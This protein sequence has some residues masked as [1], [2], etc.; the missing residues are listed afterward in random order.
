LFFFRGKEKRFG[1]F[2]FWENV[3]FGCLALGEKKKDLVVHGK[4]LVPHR[5]YFGSSIPRQVPCDF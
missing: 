5:C 2:S 4:T 3:L 1:C